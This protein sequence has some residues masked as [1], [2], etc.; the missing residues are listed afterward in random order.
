LESSFRPRTFD[1]FHPQRVGDVFTHSALLQHEGYP[2]ESGERY[3]LVAF[4]SVDIFTT[5]V[6]TRYTRI[7]CFATIFSFNWI[8]RRMTDYYSD[9]K[10]YIDENL[11]P[12]FQNW[13]RQFFAFI[14]NWGDRVEHKVE[15][16]VDE[17]DAISFIRSLDATFDK[18]NNNNSTIDHHNDDN[19]NKARWWSYDNNNTITNDNNNDVP[20]LGSA[21]SEL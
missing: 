4:L 3:I 17:K 11:P 18:D 7:S 8:F 5:T 12:T 13:L 15:V 6:P 2:I 16:L 1:H 21:H 19:N 10:E 14:G 9:S 20:K